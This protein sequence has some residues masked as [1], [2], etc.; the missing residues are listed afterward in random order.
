[1][2][3]ENFVIIGALLSLIGSLDY[4]VGTIRG[5]TQPNRAT[6]FLWA[7][8]PLI[9]VTAMLNGGVKW[10]GVLMTFMVGFGPLL[11]FLSSFV[12]KKSVWKLTKFD[13]I[14][15]ALSV[16]GLVGWSIAKDGDVAIFFSISA[17]ALAL[18]PTLVK[19][20][21]SPESERWLVF[22]LA[23]INA[24]ITLLTIKVWDFTHIGFPI[25]ILIVCLALFFIIRFR[26]GPLIIGK[27]KQKQATI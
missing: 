14:C 4:V 27:M 13:Y 3:N 18:L 20:W 2:I 9:A 10:Q 12:N 26:L 23:S 6:W 1:M 15:G 17:D 11:V 22:L 25:Y 16:L 5:K 19:S 21:K 24:I 8:A 7:F